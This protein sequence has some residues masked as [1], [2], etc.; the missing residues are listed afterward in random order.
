MGGVKSFEQ[1]F[2]SAA[3]FSP[4]AQAL[5]GEARMLCPGGTCTAHHPSSPT[6]QPEL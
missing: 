4:L 2:P 6:L 5:G 3:G 1:D